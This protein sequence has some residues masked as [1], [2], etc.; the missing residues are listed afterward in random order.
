[1]QG[2]M[3]GE[4]DR[5]GPRGAKGDWRGETTPPCTGG[6]GREGSRPPPGLFTLSSSTRHTQCCA[7]VLSCSRWG[8]TR[9]ALST[10][11]RPEDQG[12]R[13]GPCDK[14]LGPPPGCTHP[15]CPSDLPPNISHAPGSS[16]AVKGFLY[17][18]GGLCAH[19]GSH[20]LPRRCGDLGSG[21]P[22]G[23]ASARPPPCS[24]PREAWSLDCSRATQA[25][26]GCRQLPFPLSYCPAPP[27]SAPLAT[28]TSR[29]AL[30][31]T[32]PWDRSGS[33]CKTRSAGGS[34]P[35]GGAPCAHGR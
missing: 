6:P 24:H 10:Q 19:R 9:Q 32:G 15:Q 14:E 22:R 13:T 8:R 5:W 34:C 4:G 21:D 17:K 11:Q 31:R 26:Q 1:M 25:T 7:H 2:P 30:V 16:L 3:G 35:Q 12:P 28:P 18:P 23:P 29:G 27:W 33:F 20:G